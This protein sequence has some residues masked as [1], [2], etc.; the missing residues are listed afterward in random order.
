MNVIPMS[1]STSTV[2]RRFEMLGTIEHEPG[3][4][5]ILFDEKLYFSA[6]VCSVP[7]M[8]GNVARHKIIATMDCTCDLTGRLTLERYWQSE[9]MSREVDLSEPIIRALSEKKGLWMKPVSV[10]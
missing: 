10:A 4:M 5:W 8:Q 3:R 7:T 9:K 1:Y 2:Y 6:V